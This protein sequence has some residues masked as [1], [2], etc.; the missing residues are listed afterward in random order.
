MEILRAISAIPRL[1]L[2]IIIVPV[3]HVTVDV[4]NNKDDYKEVDLKGS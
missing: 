3:M 2:M 4:D 1:N